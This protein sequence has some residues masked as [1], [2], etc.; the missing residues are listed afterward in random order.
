MRWMH[1]RYAQIVLAFDCR[2]AYSVS[3]L[4]ETRR[5]MTKDEAVDKMMHSDRTILAETCYELHK[6]QYGVSGH[7]L[8]EKSVSELVSWLLAH[9]EW[10]GTNE[11]WE[12]KVPFSD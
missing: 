3:N 9:Y 5:H 10:D 8:M 12:S 7:H 1:S 11:R 2:G 6:D 4:N